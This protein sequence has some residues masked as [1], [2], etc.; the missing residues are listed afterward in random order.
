MKLNKNTAFLFY[1]AAHA[2]SSQYKNKSLASYGHCATF[3]LHATKVMQAT[4]GGVICTN[5]DE[6]AER[7]RDIRTY[8]RN[9]KVNDSMVFNGRFSELQAT[10]ALLSLEKFPEHVKNN[11]HR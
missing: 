4:E 2:V 7:I 6:L 8:R 1:D 3:S 9:K 10:M 5:D 11:K